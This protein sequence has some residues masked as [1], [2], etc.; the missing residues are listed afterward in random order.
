LKIQEQYWGVKVGWLSK[1]V[2]DFILPPLPNLQNCENT[3]WGSAFQ[4]EIGILRHAIGHGAPCRFKNNEIVRPFPG[5]RLLT[6]VL[7]HSTQ[8]V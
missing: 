2:S 7:Y 1:K 8:L 4:K 5:A 3:M 6:I